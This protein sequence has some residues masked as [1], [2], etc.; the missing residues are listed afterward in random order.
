M[1]TPTLDA[2]FDALCERLAAGELLCA[3]DI[4]MHWRDHPRVQRLMQ[5]AR[6]VQGMAAEGTERVV[7]APVQPTVVSSGERLGA[8]HLLKPLG[9]GGMGQVWLAARTDGTDH[10]VAIKLVREAQPSFAER[11]AM[12]RQILARL[13]HP[14]IARFIDAGVTAQG[15]PWLALEYIEGQ[16][17]GVWSEKERPGLRQRLA[18][19]LRICAAVEHAHRHLVVHRDLKPSNV[20]VNA[21]GEPRLLDFGIAKLLDSSGHEFTATA[22]T[23]AYAAPEQIRGQAI[24]TATDVYALGLLLFRLLAG[25]LPS[26]RESNSLAQVLAH[27]DDEETQ[28]VSQIAQ[29]NQSA[30]PYDARVLQGDLDAIVSK[31]MRAVPEA[32]FASVAELAADL[33][34]YMDGLPVLARVPTFW[35]RSARFIRRNQ[36]AVGLSLIAALAVLG[37]AGLALWQARVAEKAATLAE[38]EASNARQSAK[39]AERVTEFALKTLSE[40]NPHGRV[41][42]KIKS[43]AELIQ[44]RIEVAKTQLHDDPMALANILAKFAEIQS[45]MG[46]AEQAEQTLTYALAALDPTDPER[47][48]TKL[49]MQYTLATVLL[50]QRR[51]DEAE[52]VLLNILP[53]VAK[54]PDL[55]RYH[56]LGYSNLA[57]IARNTGRTDEAIVRLSKAYELAKIAY[58]AS[59]ANT[60]ELLAN[61]AMLLSEQ[62]RWLESKATLQQAIGEYEAHQGRDFPRLV[63]PL[64]QLASIQ[65]RFGERASAIAGCARAMQIAQASFSAEDPHIARH[66][67]SCAQTLLQLGEF[68]RVQ[69]L[70]QES[71]AGASERTEAAFRGALMLTELHLLK[72]DYALAQ[73]QLQRTLTLQ[74]SVQELSKKE[75]ARLTALTLLTDAALARPHN[76]PTLPL[77]AWVCEQDA[78]ICAAHV[79]AWQRQGQTEQ[80]RQSFVEATTQLQAKAMDVSLFG[81]YQLLLCEIAIKDQQKDAAQR[82]QSLA[83]SSFTQLPADSGWRQ[84]RCQSEP[85]APN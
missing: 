27:L 74:A 66:R 49:R 2:A 54:Q 22:L 17:L 85:A 77:D 36:L 26:T 62:E 40:M 61:R 53:E 34:R 79:L 72:R 69:R 81:A 7:D 42:T 68:A 33:Q 48:A 78:L 82:W 16:T 14:N 43:G 52:K 76:N 73:A 45:I 5:L 32:R 59:H 83:A 8:W 51:F 37:G 44:E 39:T 67:Y 19:F 65:A 57:L 18:L 29:T 21:D 64:A 30:L 71:T 63:L 31:A 75:R 70:M 80:A 38:Q 11:M 6:V 28:R 58:G 60:I 23:P 1:S 24:T 56:A 84:I 12:E 20:M 9:S 46:N 15:S 55:A 50:L 25:A 13:S 4:P 41:T 10:L 3:E 35:Y 47:T